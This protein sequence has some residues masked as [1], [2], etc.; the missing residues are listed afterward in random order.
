MPTYIAVPLGQP[1]GRGD[2]GWRVEQKRPG[3]CGA[4]SFEP[5]P[6]AR[7]TASPC[8]AWRASAAGSSDRCEDLL[9]PHVADPHP[10]R[11]HGVGDGAE[12]ETWSSFSLR[13]RRIAACCSGT[14]ISSPVSPTFQ[15]NGGVPP[16]YRPC[17]AG[18]AS[19]RRSSLA[20]GRL[21][22]RD[23]RQDDESLE[24]PLPVVSPPRSIMCTAT[25]P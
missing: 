17:A 14:A 18:H 15:P 4:W 7:A 24:T 3:A 9:H 13:I 22:R 21:G 1:S 23:C 19:P 2:R 8:A 6:A 12:R 20:C 5:A 16:R 25:R 10:C 11:G